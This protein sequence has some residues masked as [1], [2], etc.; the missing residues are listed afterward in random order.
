MFTVEVLDSAKALMRVFDISNTAYVGITESGHEKTTDT[1]GFLFP[2]VVKS[3]WF[4][5]LVFVER[6]NFVIGDS[7]WFN[8][9]FVSE[10]TTNISEG[11]IR[12]RSVFR[13]T[14]LAN[15]DLPVADITALEG[16]LEPDDLVIVVVGSELVDLISDLF[17]SGRHDERGREE[18]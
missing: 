11:H 18:Q 7:L 6:I 17:G 2:P 12:N 5:D 3:I 4:D 15:K 1:S 14:I 10:V 13:G 8:T 9:S 16:T